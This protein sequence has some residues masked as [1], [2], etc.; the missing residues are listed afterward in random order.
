MFT[1][2]LLD[3]KAKQILLCIKDT[4]KVN[5][6]MLLEAHFLYLC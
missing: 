3:K 5:A 6:Q 1:L 2:D 4:Y